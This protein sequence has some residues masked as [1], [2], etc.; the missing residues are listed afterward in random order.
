[1]KTQLHTIRNLVLKG[2]GIGLV[3][4][5]I[6][7]SNLK[8]QALSGTKTIPGD[9]ATIAAAVTDLN[10]SG[11]AT[12]GVTFN[13]A[14]GYTELLTA[15]ISVTATGTATMPIV[16]QKDPATIGANP[17]ITAY[18]G[19]NIPTSSTQDGIWQFI[20]SDYI[21]INGIDLLDPNATNPATMEFGYSF[22]K[23]SATN[24]A[25]NNTIKNCTIS[26]NAINN[27]SATAPAVE[28]SRGIQIMNSTA[29]AATTNLTVTSAAGASS[30]NKFYSNTIKN[31]NYGIVL[32]GYA[33][34]A[35][36]TLADTLNDIGGNSP[37]T[38]N[39]IINFG[40]ATAA[41]N[42]AMAI[43]T[44]AQYGINV[45]YNTINSNDGNGVLH[46]NTLSG[47]Y[48]NTAAGA[49][50]NC[51]YN[52]I[53]IKGGGTTQ[54]IYA[55]N[56]AMGGAATGVT[57]TV[58]INN[59]IM[60]S[61]KYTTATSGG[62]YAINAAT[63]P[64]NIYINNNIIRNCTINNSTGTLYGITWPSNPAN[65]F[66]KNNIVYNLTKNGAGNLYCLYSNSS[67][68]NEDVSNNK[69]YDLT[70]TDASTTTS[71]IY[72]IYQNTATGNKVYK[73]NEIYNLSI[74]NSTSTSN[75]IYGLRV[76]YGTNIDMSSNTV[77]GLSGNVNTLVAIAGA[78]ITTG[79][80]YAIYKNKVY[81]IKSTY[82]G[83][84]VVSG[85][86]GSGGSYTI[87]N[88]LIGNLMATA[89][90]SIDAIRGISITAT[91][92]S[93]YDSIFNNTVYLN[94]TST[95]TNF[96]SSG[97]YHTASATA[98]TANLSLRNNII[99]NA[100]TA[101]GTGF[102]AAYRRSGTALDNYATT[103][104][105]NLVY[106]GTPSAANLIF[107]DG[108]NAD[109]TLISYKTRMGTRDLS[110]ISEMPIY[111]NTMG[112]A[113]D[114][115]FIST[116]V[117]TQ[118]E[119]GGSSIVGYGK[120]F[121]DSTRAGFPNYP[122]Q[123]NGGGTNPDIGAWEFDGIPV[124]PP[125]VSNITI[126]PNDT[127][128]VATQRTI[129]A[130]ISTATGYISAASI[131]YLVNGV[132]Q[133]P[134]AMTNV[135]G[136]IWEGVIPVVT[137]GNATVI[138]SVSATNSSNTN[139]SKAG[140]IYQD[141]PLTGAT[142]FV[143]A[144][145]N[146]V[147]IANTNTTLTAKVLS[148]T[149]NVVLG[150]GATTAYYYDGIFYHY[151]GGAKT[152]FLIQASELR[153]IGVIP[154]IIDSLGITMST[155]TP[156]TYTGF[157]IQMA[158]TGN[159]NMSGGLISSGFKS[160]Y[161]TPDYVPVTGSNIFPFQTPFVWDGVSN[162]V[163][164]F[165]WSNGT[166]ST[167]GGPFSGLAAGTSNFAKTDATP[168]VSCAYYYGDAQTKADLCA[169]TVSSTVGT[170][171][172]GTL[173]GRPQFSF[174]KARYII[175][176][177][178]WS[179]GITTIG[180]HNPQSV[181][182][183]TSSS[184]TVTA[185]NPNGC[186]VTNT[187]P[188]TV[189]ATNASMGG[190]YTVGSSGNYATL[191]A[192]VDAY[193]TVC[194]VTGPIVFELTD[195]IYG[196][197]E[198]FPIVLRGN[199]LVSATNTLTIKPATGVNANII[200]KNTSSLIQLKGSDFVT[201]DGSNNGTNSRNLTIVNDTSAYSVLWISSNGNADGASNINVKNTNIQGYSP[202]TFT[203]AG[204]SLGGSFRPDI[205]AESRSKN[206]SIGN[207]V[208]T[209]IQTGIAIYGDTF[210]LD[211]N[212]NIADNIMGSANA[213]DSLTHRGMYLSN[214]KYS[215]VRNNT[216]QGI[217]SSRTFCAGIQ[218]S[219]NIDSVNIKSNRI[220]NVKNIITNAASGI[221]LNAQSPNSKLHISNNSI[222]GVSSSG[223]FTTDLNAF[224]ITVISGGGYYIYFNS[225]NMYSSQTT[226]ISSAIYFTTGLKLSNSVYIKNNVFTNN[227][228][229]N[230]QRYAIYC[231]APNTI[232]SHINYNNYFA[233]S[234]TMGYLFLT[235]R[236]NLASWKSAIAMD[237][238]SISVSP[239]FISNELLVPALGNLL[240]N[241]GVL[242]SG[243]TRDILDTVRNI[244]NPSMGAYEKGIDAMGPVI[245]YTGIPN[246]VNVSNMSFNNVTII[247]PSGVN[248]T[249]GAKP[250][251][252]Y[253]RKV[254][255][256]VFGNYPTD[257]SSGFNGWKY[258]EA[259]N[260]HSPFNFIIDYSLF[261]S[262][263]SINDTIQYFVT[264]QDIT[265]QAYTGANPEAGYSSTNVNSIITAPTTPSSYIIVDAPMAG[266]YNIGTGQSQPWGYATITQ[267]FNDL[268]LRGVSG[269]VQFKL[270]DA[271]Y[272]ALENFPIT[273]NEI[274]GVSSINN[275]M[276]S[277]ASGVIST[278]SGAVTTGIFKLNGA[279]YITIDGSNNGT[280]TKDLTISNTN[281][282]AGSSA[283]LLASLGALAGCV[284]DTI[285]NI[286]ITTGSN[287]VNTR[288]IHIT[289]DNNNN[290]AIIGNSIKKAQIGIGL[291][292]PTTTG[293]HI[294][295]YVAKNTIGDVL[296]TMSIS[297][298][299]I[300]L[301]GT[302]AAIITQ[303]TIFNIGDN[304]TGDNS[305]IEINAN[306][307]KTEISRNKIDTVFNGSTSGYAAVGIDV[308]GA[309]DSI[310]MVNNIIERMAIYN[311]DSSSLA[312]NP[313]G[314]RLSSGS[315]H[316]VYYNSVN[317]YGNSLSGGTKGTRS[318]ALLISSSGGNMDIRNNNLANSYMGLTGSNSYAIFS[319]NGSPFAFI[320]N[321]NYYA[322]G[323]YGKLG[324]IG[325]EKTT[326]ATWKQ[327]VSQDVLS[328]NIPSGYT[329]NNDLTITQGTT[330][331][332]ESGA[333][334]IVSV[335][336]DF[337][338][339]PR[340]KTTST[341]Y[342]G[343]I[344]PDIGALEFDGAPVDGTP[345][346]IEVKTFSHHY[347][348]SN[349]VVSF[350]IEDKGA[351]A[352]GVDTLQSKP[353]IYYKKKYDGN[354]FIV[355]N[356]SADSGWKWVEAGNSASP[357]SFTIDF[358]KVLGGS[359]SHLDSINYFVIAQDKAST[360]NISVYPYEGFVG[361]SVGNITTAPTL[362]NQFMIVTQTPLNGTY[363]IG[364]SQNY[365]TINA[366]I[367]D[368]HIRGIDG[369]V[370]FQLTDANYTEVFPIEIY[371]IFG[372][373]EI[374]K[375]T[376]RP[377]SGVTPLISGSSTS[378]IFRLNGTD[379]FTFDGSNSGSSSR[380]MTIENT[381]TAA[382]T[383]VIWIASQG[384]NAGSH[385]ITIKNITA[386]GGNAIGV[387]N[388]VIYIAGKVYS[389]STTSAGG[390]GEQNDSILI[391]NNSIQKAR[392]G[393]YAGSPADYRSVNLRIEK[394]DLNT[395]GN[396]ALGMR[397]IRFCG[398]NNSTI[399]E[400]NIG[401]FIDTAA[402]TTYRSGVYIENNTNNIV[403]EKN[404]ISNIYITDA[405]YIY[406]PKGIIIESVNSSSASVSNI[407]VLNNFISNIK[408][409]GGSYNTY[410]GFYIPG[411]I[412]LRFVMA[413]GILVANNTIH[414][415]GNTLN[416]E[417]GNI[418]AGIVLDDDAKASL[419]NNIIVNKLG[420]S[421]ATGIG[422]FGI[423]CENSIT[424]LVQ[425]DYN[426]IYANATGSG[427]N[428]IGMIAGSIYAT[429][430]DW[431]YSTSI[432][433]HSIS[434]STQ[435]V[436]PMDLHLT[437][438]TLGNTAYIGTPLSIV[439]TDI[440]GNAR[441]VT[442]YMGADESITHP[443]PVKLI[444]FTAATKSNDAILNWNTAT[445]TNNKG[446]YI[447]RSMDGR[448]FTSIDFVKGA[449]NSNKA[450]GYNYTDANVFAASQ[451]NILYY[452]LKQVDLDGKYVYS[453]VV[454]VTKY[455]KEANS[456]CVS[457]NPYA[458]NYS[459]T[460]T[461]TADGTAT[462]EMM[463]LQG[464]VVASQNAVVASGANTIL[465][466]EASTLKAGIYF[467][468]MSINGEMQT[469]KLVKN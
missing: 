176:G 318:A 410:Q 172:V 291:I 220:Y 66:V 393:I 276:L 328:V 5:F 88:N 38:G 128:C 98:T 189:N 173:S 219:N 329:A 143:T 443:L 171:G 144:S 320:N 221:Y 326:I 73:Q 218:L 286:N 2:L 394:N 164:Q 415:Y 439:T 70:I 200:G 379:Y 333:V 148:P 160:V 342:G 363:T 151:Y 338:G 435:F 386:R 296:G 369:P 255:L 124:P 357:F 35:P 400:N 294:G 284:S 438:S 446:F 134:V 461:A 168:F 191:T 226:G 125:V 12:G 321:N 201:I 84:T 442:P 78:G 16:F 123:L 460:F 398:I 455:A 344:L 359:V 183:V 339:E 17:L 256:N 456:L 268:S 243:I 434:D 162:I 282:T 182:P 277:P 180:T 355:T 348:T 238:N 289:G 232:F 433:T 15:T 33:A 262:S 424:Q 295:L 299:G 215:H 231:A 76:G 309:S 96:G 211:S 403:V 214:V 409:D 248:T 177:Y 387:E 42:Q 273:I 345:P 337:N 77:F 316:K 384:I 186:T 19:T 367:N 437:G 188:Y 411:G 117:A 399:V 37:A 82:T 229:A 69:V 28:G 195:N 65:L 67:S 385:H 187:I 178:A 60:D 101:K 92:T 392:N 429:L 245:T 86:L 149:K 127:Q 365:T 120:D 71:S 391:T 32:I 454:R 85:I 174:G 157:E 270:L 436:A 414:L 113:N 9:Y 444:S 451:S 353:R 293:L 109:Q 45:S 41:T 118:I 457:P 331:A 376:I 167:A 89:A 361:T 319:S 184:Y 250:R 111:T 43:R 166:K 462:L 196:P 56:I 373:S 209:K 303:N 413:G 265:A 389:T 278:I 266:T 450:I 312:D 40:G 235:N 175:S 464:K 360:P 4:A 207:N 315:G 116:A 204:L 169:Q 80:K 58:N 310:L 145:K 407:K 237:S 18:V 22:Y 198:T 49:S 252:Y 1:M 7:T 427:I 59:N 253:K 395:S 425:S 102:T 396:T 432:D 25:Q 234:P 51:N 298:T 466:N 302:P 87:Y 351:V 239:Q 463:D 306:C 449:S 313:F 3:F 349:K 135:S 104:N 21:T 100:S 448:S 217:S 244:T 397:G 304:T 95:G 222:S 48:L 285:K 206:I 356:S 108:T 119:S 416:K 203:V 259:S 131:N 30:Y 136:N 233:N 317:L 185:T 307:S 54:A 110:S 158:H 423:V 417:T 374:N 279:D 254:E 53:Y 447:E 99:V 350:N 343:N 68:V 431:C 126:T 165:C 27:A 419:L 335:P 6:G 150:T 263:V 13:I 378:A 408:G 358:S 366:A 212:I 305:A 112:S 401:N 258:T 93:S 24:G 29:V 372:A 103:S 418:S 340:P 388:C 242:I 428:A 163:V 146:P 380:N 352:T 459:I 20:G 246:A 283:I 241:K 280:T 362:P 208:F 271:N 264:A 210:L 156:F 236:A 327:A 381:S 199:Q 107:Y 79:A 240:I 440:D 44:L 292:A 130:T 72:G 152:Q 129:N 272:G 347:G 412:Y 62:Y 257:N 332:L 354:Q 290:I 469:L 404:K 194:N 132:L 406:A 322:T 405:G 300:K 34:A 122:V 133:T 261:T 225:V 106:A 138:T 179:D 61:C 141:E 441:T 452:R 228:T 383:T 140:P 297:K 114:F 52:T 115:L 301:S 97:I 14:A 287:T 224:G 202:K 325:S 46:P 213:A 402:Q 275:I 330:S 63:N 74:P 375:I 154:G 142:V 247:D 341:N 197:N 23:T 216:I 227:S 159:T 155:V 465:V 36:Y 147:C 422:T 467:V 364:A 39:S 75:S 47:I 267:A 31:C 223:S 91:T 430:G 260:A 190:A 251:V 308:I 334:A 50:G 64:T 161:L 468:R 83:A 205:F 230:H 137:P 274:Q 453:Q 153:N 311:Y 193:N 281:A 249:A 11:V 324:Y 458:N 370:T 90:S 139:G 192:A 81:D 314:I 269:A 26:L 94:A 55:I 10:T 181:S 121:V 8:A 170:N 445:E 105:N 323:P 421:G 426:N 390:K 336:T 346:S 377:A 371:S 57:N 288:G 368:L 382:S 420:L